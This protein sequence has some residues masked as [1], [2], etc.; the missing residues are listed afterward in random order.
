MDSRKY[1]LQRQI[2][3]AL[4][5]DDNDLL[6]LLKSQW[7]HRY[8][9]ESLEE[10]KNQ[11]LNEVK[12][13]PTS[14]DNQEFDQSGDSFS[15]DDQAISI[16]EDV[17]QVKE[18][19]NDIQGI[20]KSVNVEKKQSFEIKSYEIADKEDYQNKSLTP[21][22]AYKSPPKVE[23]LIPLPPKPKYGFLKKWLIRS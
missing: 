2:I 6:S 1:Q 12:Q 4:K 23:A 10:L 7:A 22:G 14:Q 20:E 16:N 5:A 17:N 9:V 3:E 13:N 8:G 21:V 18:I 11:D 19:R 15:E